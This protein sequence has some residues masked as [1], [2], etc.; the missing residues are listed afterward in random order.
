MIALTAM[1]IQ[2]IDNN[3]DGIRICRVDGES[4]V[5]V[6]VPRDM[7]SEAKSLPDLPDRGV[8]Y[9]LD[10]DH[11]VLSRAYVGQTTKGLS[12]LDAHKTKK[13]FWNKAIMFLD[14]DVN[15]DRDVLDSLESTAIDYVDKHGSYETDNGYTPAPRM[16]P[17]KEQQVERLHNNILFRMRVLG[18]DLDRKEKTRLWRTPYSIRRRT[19]F[20]P[21]GDIAKVQVVSLFFPVLKWIS[22]IQLLKTREPWQLGSS[23]SE[24]RRARRL[25]LMTLNYQALPLLLYLFSV[26]V[27]TVGPNG[28]MNKDRPLITCTETRSI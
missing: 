17:Y 8:Y 6:V 11:G 3:P 2:I 1:T 26:A 5:T 19:V 22:C 27:K 23:F 21:L 12:R 10:E 28:S 20:R 9:L 24:R 7:L 16:N 14:N 15:I 18:Y 13:D 25:L 4:L